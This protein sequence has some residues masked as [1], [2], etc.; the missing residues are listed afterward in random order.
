MSFFD[1]F[2]TYAVCIMTKTFQ[3]YFVVYKYSRKQTWHLY[4]HSAIQ[5][6]LSP[7]ILNV[8]S[9]YKLSTQSLTICH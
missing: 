5:Q 9:A 7:G 8:A 6:L 3:I 2:G 1:Q 4:I